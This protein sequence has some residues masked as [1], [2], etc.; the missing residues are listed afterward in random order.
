[1]TS[2][3]AERAGTDRKAGNRAC[4]DGDT[5]ERRRIIGFAFKRKNVSG[6]LIVC[7]YRINSALSHGI[8]CI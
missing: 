2:A 3:L 5:I 4:I 7:I 6:S 1:M 8:L